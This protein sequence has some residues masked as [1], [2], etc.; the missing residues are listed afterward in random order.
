PNHFR[1]PFGP[2]WSLV[3]D[4]G[5]HRDAITGHG[6]SDALRDA[7]LLA[8]A[9]DTTLRCPSL[10]VPALAAY[11]SHRDRMSARIFEITVALAA[12]PDQETFVALQRDLAVAI[13]D[14]AGELHSRPLPRPADARLGAP[15]HA[16]L[17]APA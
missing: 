16:A 13:D 4:A 17:T 3:G 7:E 11:E 9:V 5:Y 15:T 10:E 6:I 8:Q 14:L 1:K 2:G 12:F